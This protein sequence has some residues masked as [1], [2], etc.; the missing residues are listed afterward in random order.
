MLNSQRQI[1]PGVELVHQHHGAA[2][3][4]CTKQ[5]GE[6]EIRIHRQGQQRDRIRRRGGALQLDP[7][8][9]AGLHDAL[10]QTGGA[11][12]VNDVERLVWLTLHGLWLRRALQPLRPGGFI[13]QH[14]WQRRAV[15]ARLG[16]CIDK[17]PHRTRVGREHLQLLGRGRGGQGCHRHTG[18]HRTQKGAHISQR[19]GRAD[20]HR[21]ARLHAIALQS[22]GHLLHTRMQLGKAQHLLA[23][24]QGRVRWPRLRVAGQQ[25]GQSAK[26]AGQERVHGVQ[27][28]SSRPRMAV[29]WLDSVP[30]LPCASA[31]FTP[32]TWRSPPSPRN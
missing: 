12:G 20:R 21:L 6:R 14:A 18:L 15:P 7:T 24:H 8:H 29:D 3:A 32:C 22:T 26:G 30:P 17:D 1:A 2:H 25:L 16:L 4:H 31:V 11:R 9:T 5:V 27:S 19:G 13:E 10:G 28:T 23:Q